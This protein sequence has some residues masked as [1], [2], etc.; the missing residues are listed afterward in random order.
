MSRLRTAEGSPSENGDTLPQGVR[1]VA[2]GSAR[3]FCRLL[4]QATP[5]VGNV[6]REALGLRKLKELQ[7]QQEQEREHDRKMDEELKHVK[8]LDSDEGEG[9]PEG[10][11]AGTGSRTS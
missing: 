10:D 2:A 8:P 5:V 3:S 4:P 7:K 1:T 11:G 9:A 6:A